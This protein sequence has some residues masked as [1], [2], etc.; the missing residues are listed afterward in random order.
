MEC[1]DFGI[2]ID[3]KGKYNWLSDTIEFLEEKRVKRKQTKQR[4]K[5]KT[6]KNKQ[7]NPNTKQKLSHFFYS[8][9]SVNGTINW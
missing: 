9:C 2:Y 1:E 4:T 8:S 5:Q 6:N 7:T 3:F